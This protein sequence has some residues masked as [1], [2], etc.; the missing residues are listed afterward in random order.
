MSPAVWLVLPL[1]LAV[2]I[3]AAYQGTTHKY[4]SIS[5]ESS[6]YF[7][8]ACLG[9]FAVPAFFL[10]MFYLIFRKPAS[11]S[12]RLLITFCSASV[13]GILS[14]VGTMQASRILPAKAAVVDPALTA[15]PAKRKSQLPVRTP[16]IWDPAI[17][18]LYSDLK[19]SNEAYVAAVSKL[20]LSEPRLYSPE[21]FRGTENIQRT[22]DQLQDRLAVADQFS[23]LDPILAKM[24]G[25]VA[26]IDGSAAEKREF[27]SSFMPTVQRSVANRTA[28]SAYEHD[29]L[30]ASVA[31]YQ[32]M[33]ANQSAYTF[34]ADGQKGIIKNRDFAKQV[35][36]KMQKVMQLK[37]QFLRANDAYLESQ[38]SARAQMGMPE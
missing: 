16:T 23:S 32:Y 36:A 1:S 18:S 30:R 9:P 34:S 21:S 10:L 22:I 37:Q 3:F 17:I 14:L 8:G 25:Y 12:S 4:G 35:N 29:W 27:L 31:L 19:A 2:V 24:P 33:Q 15:P 6:G 26:A 5:P 13:L 7:L 38:E 28:A 20:D 11:N